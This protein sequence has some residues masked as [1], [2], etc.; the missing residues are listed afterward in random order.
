MRGI[1]LLNSVISWAYIHWINWTTQLI[2]FPA[3]NALDLLTVYQ[4]SD[5]LPCHCG[6]QR[7]LKTSSK[8]WQGQRKKASTR[9]VTSI[10]LPLDAATLTLWLLPMLVPSIYLKYLLIQA[11]PCCHSQIWLT[12]LL[13]LGTYRWGYPINVIS[14]AIISFNG[15]AHV[16][17][18]QTR[19]R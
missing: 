6:I 17:S 9:R 18:K 7:S 16:L 11:N 10:G 13:D 4:K 3:N 1:V 14:C 8:M 15:R 19:L 5:N 12:Q 2:I